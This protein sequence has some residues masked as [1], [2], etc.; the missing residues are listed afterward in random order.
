LD[1]EGLVLRAIESAALA[2]KSTLLKSDTHK[3]EPQGVTGYALLAESH[4]SV[5]T[6]PEDGRAAC[7]VYTCGDHTDCEA[8]F[9]TLRVMFAAKECQVQRIE[10]NQRQE[11]A[12]H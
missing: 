9:E 10:R 3:F 1:N 7:D 2:S 5:H 12:Q 6:W 8:A 11:A 4:I